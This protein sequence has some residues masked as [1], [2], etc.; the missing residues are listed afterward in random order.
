[1]QLNGARS[2]KYGATLRRV[3]RHAT[4]RTVYRNIGSPRDWIRGRA[5]RAY[6]RWGVFPGIDGVAALSARTLV[7]LRGL[8]LDVPTKVIP[9]GVSA[10]HLVAH[11]DREVVRRRLGAAPGDVVVV[12]VGRLSPE[13]RV[14]RLLRG[15]ADAAR[16]LAAACWIVGDG[17]E[18]GRLQD[19]ARAANLETVRFVGAVDDVGTY[20]RAADL[21]ALTSDTEGVPAVL[22]EAGLCGLPVLATAVGAIPDTVRDGI[23]GWIVAPNDAGVA[24]ALT[25]ALRQP[26]E[27][28][29]RGHQLRARVVAEY[30]IERV[31]ESYV[32]L[33]RE[34][35][36][37]RS[38]SER[39]R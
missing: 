15:F 39:R 16:G 1:V 38:T 33:Y 26:E 11:E 2:V 31:A 32:A 13:K 7:D 12:F 24:R 9:T 20:L 30:T 21:A 17:P 34:V 27:R 6:Y 10:S 14:D 8:G 23:D 4:F 18:R 37:N 25:D 28:A 3:S 29:V 36:A 35:L 19:I 5:R 22:L